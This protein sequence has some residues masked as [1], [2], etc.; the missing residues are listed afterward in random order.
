[1]QKYIGAYSLP[2]NGQNLI[3]PILK[4][5]EHTIDLQPGI[6]YNGMSATREY[7]RFYTYHTERINL[8]PGICKKI[9]KKDV[10]Y[11][12]DA[13]IEFYY[14]FDDGLN[15]FENPP[16][17]AEGTPNNFS[18]INNDSVEYGNCLAMYS[19]SSKDD[20][21]IITID[22]IECSNT[23]AMILELDY[24]S[25]IPFEVGIYGKIS[26]TSNTHVYLSSMRML[27]NNN[28]GWNKMYIILGKVWSQISY[29]PFR[30]Y[31]QPFNTENIPKGY[32]HIDNI[33]V[34]HYQD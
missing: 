2:K 28:S 8:E 11:N 15:H 16:L 26:K 13:D 10:M 12:T 7:Y 20:Y 31:F 21:K 1:D 30:I 33:K 4:E 34:V 32:I 22:S 23:N 19:A 24:H 29:Q 14:S 9:S 3:I 6:K 5:G 27:A 25:N 18:I 17:T